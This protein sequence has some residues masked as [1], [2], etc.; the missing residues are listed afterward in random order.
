M[1]EGFGFSNTYV[2]EAIKPKLKD[3]YIQ[4]WNT[5]LTMKKTCGMY[6]LMKATDEIENYLI[7]LPCHQRHTISRFRCRNNK[8]P[9]THGRDVE[10]VVDG[11]LCPYCDY[12]V[13]GDKFHY[14]FVCEY[15]RQERNK[16]IDEKWTINP[17]L[18]FIHDVFQ[19]N[20]ARDL[21]NLVLFIDIIVEA[22]SD[23][24]LPLQTLGFQ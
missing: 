23:A 16:C 18:R 14:L 2:K 19:D 17:Q 8:L 20:D 5:E 13:L 1:Y 22:F 9:I 10:I 4:E 3:M 21:R 6:K 12:D 11:M 15:F 24:E 7:Q